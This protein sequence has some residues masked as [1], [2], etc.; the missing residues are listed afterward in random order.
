MLNYIEYDSIVKKCKNISKLKNKLYG[1]ESLYLFGGL[2][3]LVRINDKVQRLNRI[4]DKSP[5]DI[6]DTIYDLINYA[7]YFLMYKRN[8]LDKNISSRI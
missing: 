6:E 1:S 5:E 4:K 3:I 8:K 2:A 7:L